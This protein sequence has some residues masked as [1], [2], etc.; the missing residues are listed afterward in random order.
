MRRQRVLR[1]RLCGPSECSVLC[2]ASFA[3]QDASPFVLGQVFARWHVHSNC[4][5]KSVC[6]TCESCEQVLG[7]FLHAASLDVMCFSSARLWL[8]SRS[9][10]SM[11][12]H[13]SSIH[14]QKLRI[15]TLE[16]Q[17]SRCPQQ[18]STRSPF[19]FTPSQTER[20]LLSSSNLSFLRLPRLFDDLSKSDSRLL[21]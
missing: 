20:A 4:L 10:V 16:I 13:R 2:A 15:S 19:L 8:A 18:V 14:R 17:P 7:V 12:L 21:S 3:L 11:V 9:S 1:M 6:F 5:F